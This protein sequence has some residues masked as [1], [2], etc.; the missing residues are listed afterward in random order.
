MSLIL[1]LGWGAAENKELF[2]S[3]SAE[4]DP[5]GREALYRMNTGVPR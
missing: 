5:V 1:L 2:G 4:N 3:G